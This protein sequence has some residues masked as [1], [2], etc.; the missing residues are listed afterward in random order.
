MEETDYFKKDIFLYSDIL[1]FFI[2][3]GLIAFLLLLKSEKNTLIVGFI[4]FI[5]I[6]TFACKRLYYNSIKPMSMTEDEKCT[7]FS[8]KI[9]E[10]LE[11]S[12]KFQV[13]FSFCYIYI[14][15]FVSTFVWGLFVYI[16]LYCIYCSFTALQDVFKDGENYLLNFKPDKLVRNALL[17]LMLVVAGILLSYMFIFV[18]PMSF[19][20][21]EKCSWCKKNTKANKIMIIILLVCFLGVFFCMERISYFLINFNII[22]NIKPAKPWVEFFDYNKLFHVFKPTSAN[23]YHIVIFMIGLLVSIIYGIINI[24]TVTDYQDCKD[25]NRRN[26]FI[27]MIDV[28][29]FSIT[30]LVI[31][32]YTVLF[33]V[34]SFTDKVT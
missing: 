2:F 1:I 27:Q 12:N 6:Y 24:P 18:T 30:V 20:D 9:I 5:I 32:M 23:F 22:T 19:V 10:S 21:K 7:A 28:G 16:F 8:S 4:I 3:L 14:F 29:F 34:K 15:S 13:V 17:W 26:K 11:T 25:N 33:T 31:L